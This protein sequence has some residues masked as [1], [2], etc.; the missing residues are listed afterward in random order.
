MSIDVPLPE[1]PAG[2]SGDFQSRWSRLAQLVISN[3]V[4][5]LFGQGVASGANFLTNVLIARYCLPMVSASNVA[6]SNVGTFGI[7]YLT[8]TI[9]NVMAGAQEQLVSAPYT[10]YSQRQDRQLSASYAA[11]SF[12]HQWI[13]GLVMISVFWSYAL[14]L[15]WTSQSPNLV[16]AAKFVLMVAPFFLLRMFFRKLLFAHFR[17]TSALALD[18][19]QLP[20]CNCPIIGTLAYQGK[21]TVFAALIALAAGSAVA[22]TIWL[23]SFRPQLTFSLRSALEDWKSNWKFG[24]WA[25][26]TFL[27]GSTTPYTIPWLVQI[28]RND[29]TVTGRFSACQTIVGLANVVMM[30]VS[31]FLSPRSAH[32]YAHGGTKEVLRVLQRTAIF[33]AVVMGTLAGLFAASGD[34]L[35]SLIMGDEFTNLGQPLTLLSLGLLAASLSMTAGNGLWAIDRPALNV[36]ADLTTLLVTF[37]CGL[38]WIPQWEVT[39]AAAAILAGAAASAMLRWMI[40]LRALRSLPAKVATEDSNHVPQ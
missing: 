34:R 16:A 36:W 38:Y 5:A 27:I 1:A 39:G 8:I 33:F 15:D 11:S 7:Y 17:F 28:M 6:E 31:N 10:I 14:W 25:L 12:V 9:L 13:V 3:S 21:L 24:R 18:L 40:L 4:L 29:A 20:A 19:S 30:G 23:M 35:P 37:G 2:P 22:C 32:A 26:T